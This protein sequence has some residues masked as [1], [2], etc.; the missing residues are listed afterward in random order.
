MGSAVARVRWELSIEQN[1]R[2]DPCFYI[3]QTLGSVYVLMLQPP[4]FSEARQQ[5]IVERFSRIPATIEAAKQNLTDM[6]QPFIKLAI[7]SLDHVADR[8][9]AMEAGLSAELSPTNKD[10]LL[11][12]TPEAVKALTDFRAWLETKLPGAR[13][14]TAIGRENYIFFLRNVALQPYTPEQMLAVSRE[15]WSRSVA[16]EAYQQARLAQASLV[17]S[18]FCQRRC[19]D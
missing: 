11:K 9:G 17:G 6:R 3:D 13:K 18:D 4:P 14:E 16:F 15:E 5:E 19:P 10:A 1:W 2:R 12:A 7:D 8:T